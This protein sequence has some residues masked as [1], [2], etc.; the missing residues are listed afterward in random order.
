MP[1]SLK[2]IDRL[3]DRLTATYGREFMA[4]YDGLQE[5]AVKASWAHELEPF[6]NRLYA[7]A[8]ALENLPERCPNVIAFKQLARQAPLQDVEQL[9]SPKADPKRLSAELAKLADLKA[10]TKKLTNSTGKE[11]AHRIVGRASD[12]AKVHSCTLRFAREALGT[13]EAA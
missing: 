6:E 2:A 4:R 5:G 12:G 10:T 13:R 8:W 7:I 11:W 1:L 3:F 9:P